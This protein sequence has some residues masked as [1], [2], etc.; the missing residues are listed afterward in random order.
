MGIL[1]NIASRFGYSKDQKSINRKAFN[2]V[3]SD[4]I[5]WIK[6]KRGYQA[7]KNDRLTADWHVYDRTSDQEMR[8]ELK[9]VRS[10]ARDLY[11]NN[12][13]AKKFVRIIQN[14]VNGPNGFRL[15]MKI[16]DGFG[17]DARLDEVANRKIE[18]AWKEW[19]KSDY[20]TVSK[21]LTLRAVN[22]L[23]LTHIARDGEVFIRILKTDNKFNFAL[24][25][26]EPDHIDDKL[27][28][29]HLKND[30]YIHM[31]IEHDK[32]GKPT[33]YYV[34]KNKRLESGYANLSN[35]E[36]VPAEKIIHLYEPDRAD[37]SRGISWMVQSMI[38]MK[39]L[40]GYEEAALINARVSAAKMGF[41]TSEIGTEEYTGDSEDE[42]GNR[43]TTVSPGKFEELPAGMSFTPW[44]PSFPS[45]QHSEFV[46]RNL[47][48]IASGLGVSYNTFAND[49]ESVNYSSIRSGLLEERELWKR[50]Q[51][52]YIEQFLNKIFEVWL[53][54]SLLA[55]AIDLPYGKY[56][57]FNQPTWLPRRWDWVDP[58]KDVQAKKE[59]IALKINSRKRIAAEK[60]YDFDEIQEE[61]ATEPNEGKANE[62]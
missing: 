17:K 38:A 11:N 48:R 58:L 25:I 50:I 40:D 61:L 55:G 2:V 14:N 42:S 5:D 33:H 15:Q 59:E 35:Y 27:Y 44:N 41:F 39:M 53:E 13:Y 52:W 18:E 37:Q 30:K 7:A 8:Y 36:R 3:D 60:G 54:R 1:S 12:D 56:E 6:D 47:M 34:K 22:D 20:C 23:C 46:K 10:R 31:G 32:W 4:M 26:I 45:D 49:L 29:D 9:T 62:E 16:K 57:K 21:K 28:V 43:L 19:S 24:E 51:K